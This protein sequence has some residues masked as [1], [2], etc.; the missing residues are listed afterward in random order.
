MA[1]LWDSTFLPLNGSEYE[2]PGKKDERLRLECKGLKLGESGKMYI[3][4]CKNRFGM[5][6]VDAVLNYRKN[7]G[8]IE[9]PYFNPEDFKDEN[10][11]ER[12]LPFEE[13]NEAEKQF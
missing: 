13:Y 2:R 4:L 1:M 12:D 3:K 9:D 10:P 8:V 7:E 11:I 6:N 5:A